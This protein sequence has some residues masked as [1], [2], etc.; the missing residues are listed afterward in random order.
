[1]QILAK[2]LS[3]L[4][5]FPKNTAVFR[6]KIPTFSKA[7]NCSEHLLDACRKQTLQMFSLDCKVT[8][9]CWVIALNCQKWHHFHKGS[10]C[11]L[12]KCEWSRVSRFTL[13]WCFLSHCL[14]VP[15]GHVSPKQTTSLGPSRIFWLVLSFCCY[16][17]HQMSQRSQVSRVTENTTEVDAVKAHYRLILILSTIAIVNCTVGMYFLILPATAV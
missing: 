8:V 13:W 14:L 10:H 15:L 9:P 16:H 4:A 7:L 5:T 1:M 17:S 6:Q 12:C 11:E 2:A 3:C